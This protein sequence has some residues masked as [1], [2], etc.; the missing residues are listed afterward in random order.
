MYMTNM[1]KICTMNKLE[2][3]KILLKLGALIG[4]VLS[5]G[6]LYLR[7]IFEK[8]EKK[9]TTITASREQLE[10]PTWPATTFCMQK[11]F[12]PS[13]MIEETG[14]PNRDIFRH[15]PP[16]VDKVLNQSL[17]DTFYKAAYKLNRDFELHLLNTTD[18][19]ILKVIP[20]KV[21]ENSISSKVKIIVEEFPTEMDGLCY[22]LTYRVKEN[23]YPALFFGIIPKKELLEHPIG[24]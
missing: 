11:P 20:A 13:V 2:K 15:K 3:L 22:S 6:I 19:S 18:D 23:T 10:F 17:L 5:L 1:Q 16:Q 4:L 7:D 14:T 12:K 9:A 8:Y 24:K 21:G